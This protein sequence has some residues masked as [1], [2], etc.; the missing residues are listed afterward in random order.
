MDEGLARYR[1]ASEAN[2]I[3]G[4]MATVL[5]L[6][7]GPKVGRPPPGSSGVRC[8]RV[9]SLGACSRSH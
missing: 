3:N 4:L 9:D 7:L 2:D 8:E 5:A 1:A 6:R